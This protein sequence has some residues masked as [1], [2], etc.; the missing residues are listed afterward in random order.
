M[1]N[2]CQILA[3][4]MIPLSKITNMNIKEPAITLDELAHHFGREPQEVHGIIQPMLSRHTENPSGSVKRYR[5]SEAFRAVTFMQGVAD[6]LLAADGKVVVATNPELPPEL[7]LSGDTWGLAGSVPTRALRSLWRQRGRPADSAEFVIIN[8]PSIAEAS[9][10]E[11]KDRGPSAAYDHKWR[12]AISVLLH[13]LA[14]VV[15]MPRTPS[16][17]PKIYNPLLLDRQAR[18]ES[19]STTILQREAK[20]STDPRCPFTHH[21]LPF[22]R[23]LIHLAYRYRH[24][25]RRARVHT[26]EGVMCDWFMYHLLPLSSYVDAIGDEPYRMR[27]QPL[28]KVMATKPPEEFSEVFNKDVAHWCKTQLPKQTQE[29]Q[30]A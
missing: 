19:K 27:H 28:R 26:F 21:G 15:S 4:G 17:G 20:S 5:I 9:W 1:K 23:A 29:R 12:V 25:F 18:Q 24:H 6:R 30:T 2:E 8:T 13:E 11:I 16:L 3:T 10:S 7:Q 14:H 22:L